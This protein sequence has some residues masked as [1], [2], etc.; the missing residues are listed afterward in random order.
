MINLGLLKTSEKHH[1]KIR[2]FHQEKL[3]GSSRC[4]CCFKNPIAEIAGSHEKLNLRL[5]FFREARGEVELK[6]SV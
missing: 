6:E 5:R 4:Q 2:K 3:Y 1:A